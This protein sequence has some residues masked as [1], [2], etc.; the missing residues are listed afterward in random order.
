M[1]LINILCTLQN[2]EEKV[3]QEGVDEQEGGRD[4]GEEEEEEYDE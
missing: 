4:I 2:E 3:F 1:L